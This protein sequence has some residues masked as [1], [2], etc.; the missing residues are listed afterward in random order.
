MY[1]EMDFSHTALSMQE[2][3]FL[4]ETAIWRGKIEMVFMSFAAKNN[5]VSTPRKYQLRVFH[6][7]KNHWIGCVA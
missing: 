2:L 5:G 4:G 1:A 7:E 3:L 6:L